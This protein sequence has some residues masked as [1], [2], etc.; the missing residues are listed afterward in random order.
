MAL[1]MYCR[2]L[3]KLPNT[4]HNIEQLKSGDK[5]KIQVTTYPGNCSL[6]KSR[7][8]LLSAVE[9]VKQKHKKS[10]KQTSA[11]RPTPTRSQISTAKDSSVSPTVRL[12]SRNSEQRV[13][14]LGT[15]VYASCPQNYITSHQETLISQFF[16]SSLLCPIWLKYQKLIMDK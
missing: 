9:K 5:P 6:V 16:S 11:V 8:P 13:Y 15:P 2:S 4:Q 12:L 10:L 1:H 7:K 14:S 3:R